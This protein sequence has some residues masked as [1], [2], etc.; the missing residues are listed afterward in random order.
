[1]DVWR[2]GVGWLRALE[3]RVLRELLVLFSSVPVV[4][5]MLWHA[6]EFRESGSLESLSGNVQKYTI[7]FSLHTLREARCPRGAYPR[8]HGTRYDARAP[9]RILAFC[10]L[11]LRLLPAC[12]RRGSWRRDRGIR[13]KGRA[14]CAACDSA[15]ELLVGH[16]LRV[17]R[18]HGPLQPLLL[19]LHR[20]R[21][22]DGLP[23][24]QV[25]L[26]VEER[27]RLLRRSSGTGGPQHTS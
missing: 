8:L 27:L 12:Q 4:K 7:C 2:V 16:D 23:S 26:P 24:D 22:L 10:C 15:S 21:H 1:M 11:R 19:D 14:W 25:D 6:F 5:Y 18:L 20:L 9:Y 3:S 13:G 17:H